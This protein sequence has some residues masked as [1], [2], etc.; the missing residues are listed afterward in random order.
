MRLV[1]IA[2]KVP[3]HPGDFRNFHDRP[4]IPTKLFDRQWAGG[5]VSMDEL[6][7]DDSTFTTTWAINDYGP[8]WGF[9][10]LPSVGSTVVSPDRVDPVRARGRGGKVDTN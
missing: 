6:P 8:K 2:V 5:W 10:K 1:A 7:P 9:R 4:P 3:I